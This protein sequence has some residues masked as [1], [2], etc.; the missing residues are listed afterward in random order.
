MVKEH[1]Y[2]LIVRE[3][4]HDGAFEGKDDEDYLRR[5]LLSKIV[6]CF[7]DAD[8]DVRI[9]YIESTEVENPHQMEIELGDC[10]EM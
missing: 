3:K 7:V 5:T 4:T 9:K 6:K 2:Q 10:E 8:F 1:I